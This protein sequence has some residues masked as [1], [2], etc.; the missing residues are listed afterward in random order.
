MARGR[1][2][3]GGNQKEDRFPLF[4]LT[5]TQQQ[6]DCDELLWKK[7]TSRPTPLYPTF[8]EKGKGKGGG[9]ERMNGPGLETVVGMSGISCCATG[10]E[11]VEKSSREKSVGI[12][13]LGSFDSGPR[14]I[15]T[16]FFAIFEPPPERCA[17]WPGKGLKR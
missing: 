14:L 10:G 9:G 13:K 7:L 16:S 2:G 3:G 1:V 4:S 11:S 8:R 17:A 15:M 6:I 5:Q 12:S